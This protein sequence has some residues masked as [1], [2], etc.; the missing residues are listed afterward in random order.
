MTRDIFGAELDDEMTGDAGIWRYAGEE[1]S[2]KSV[3]GDVNNEGGDSEEDDG[4]GDSSKEDDE[5]DDDGGDSSKEDDEED[6][7]G[8]DSSNSEEDD[9]E[10]EDGGDS[11]NSEEDDEE[12]DDG[13]DSSNSEEHDE[14]D[15][16]DGVN[17]NSEEH[18]EEDEGDNQGNKSKIEFDDDEVW[19]SLSILSHPCIAEITYT[20]QK[21]GEVRRF[22]ATKHISQPTPSLNQSLY[23]EGGSGFLCV[24]INPKGEARHCFFDLVSYVNGRMNHQ[25]KKQLRYRKIGAERWRTTPLA[26][27]LVVTKLNFE[28]IVKS[29]KEAGVSASEGSII[30]IGGWQFQCYDEE[31]KNP[32]DD[33]DTWFAGMEDGDDLCISGIGTLFLDRQ[34]MFKTNFH[35]DL[36]MAID[37]DFAKERTLD[38]R[39]YWLHERLFKHENIRKWNVELD[40]RSNHDCQKLFYEGT[41]QRKLRAPVLTYSNTKFPFVCHGKWGSDNGY[42]SHVPN[43]YAACE[44]YADA[45]QV[46]EDFNSARDAVLQSFSKRKGS[47]SEERKVAIEEYHAQEK[48]L[49][50]FETK[51]PRWSG[52]MESYHPSDLYFLRH[53]VYKGREAEYMALSKENK[54][55]WKEIKRKDAPEGADD[56]WQPF[57]TKKNQYL[58]ENTAERAAMLPYIR[59]VLDTQYSRK[60]YVRTVESD[61]NRKQTMHFSWSPPR[62]CR[63][64]YEKS[65]DDAVEV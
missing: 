16:G 46:L 6:D 18:D 36:R 21:S 30:D 29:L 38:F 26:R 58:R 27:M 48:L 37:P 22:A 59:V 61:P 54:G 57:R 39:D 51:Y 41:R 40:M 17:N 1:E 49:D 31:S 2:G 28:V 12:D 11:S 52:I 42:F 43:Q 45:A 63:A 23:R 3:E 60:Q 34:K 53:Y 47:S 35:T 20:V 8:G 5:E 65:I 33:I 64:A 55:T 56:G 15:E 25:M 4:G 13:G 14:E 50:D 44:H 19:H 32:D 10:D 9:E 7:D 24:S 62:Q